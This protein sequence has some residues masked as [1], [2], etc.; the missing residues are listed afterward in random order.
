MKDQIVAI[1]REYDQTPYVHQGR[2]KGVGI[3]CIGLVICVCK[4]LDLIDFDYYD[5]DRTP[6]GDN[7]MQLLKLHCT[8]TDN[9]EPGDIMVFRIKKQPQHVGIVTE[10]GIIHAYQGADKVVEHELIQWWKDRIVGAFELP[11]SAQNSV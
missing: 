1:A 3:D 7:L 4:E 9:P 8:P 5:Y 11:S 2:V 6:D 10:R